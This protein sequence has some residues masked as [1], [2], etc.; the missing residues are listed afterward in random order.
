[1]HLILA[2]TTLGHTIPAKRLAALLGSIGVLAEVLE[3]VP[4]NYK[5][6]AGI[7]DCGH[8]RT[9]SDMA[10]IKHFGKLGRYYLHVQ[11]PVLYA[12]EKRLAEYA[13]AVFSV[14]NIDGCIHIGHLL[15]DLPRKHDPDQRLSKILYLGTG[16]NMSVINQFTYKVFK[17]N[18]DIEVVYC[19][20]N[21]LPRVETKNITM[22]KSIN[23]AYESMLGFDLVVAGAGSG[24]INECLHKKQLSLVMPVSHE[25]YQA[26]LLKYQANNNGLALPILSLNRFDAILDD[27][28][29]PGRL[30][31]LSGR[32]NDV[33]SVPDAA[34]N[35]AEI[36]KEHP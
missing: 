8:E 7:I 32:L 23:N 24:V 29:K 19:Y 3:H 17:S 4:T 13:A 35:L 21:L 28:R 27:L 11:N 12:R 36:F 1:M 25:S 30:A 9:K 26:D 6:Y 2:N 22:V 18:G 34:D 5:D 16:Q 14:F 20:R 10:A 31:E 33:N 15:N